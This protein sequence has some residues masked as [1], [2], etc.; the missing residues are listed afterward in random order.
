MEGTLF[1][2]E[3]QLLSSCPLYREVLASKGW[4]GSKDR[5]V[6][7]VSFRKRRQWSSS[8]HDREAS[9]GEGLALQD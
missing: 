4:E 7:Y 2:C 9:L 8:V 1:G 3:Q 5:Q 6:N